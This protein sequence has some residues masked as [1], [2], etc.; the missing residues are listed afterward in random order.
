MQRR[1]GRDIHPFTS[2]VLGAAGIALLSEA[3]TRSPVLW[4]EARRSMISSPI[5]GAAFT[6]VKKILVETN[7]VMHLC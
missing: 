6:K 5:W 7:I 3:F 4:I 1:K 2:L